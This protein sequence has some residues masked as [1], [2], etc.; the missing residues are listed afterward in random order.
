ML[1]I[2]VSPYFYWGDSAPAKIRFATLE[3]SEEGGKEEGEEGEEKTKP[4]N[5]LT[6]RTVEEDTIVIDE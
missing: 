4:D 2:S 3:D 6:V 1:E 5:E